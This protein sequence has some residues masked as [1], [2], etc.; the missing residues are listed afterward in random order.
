MASSDLGCAQNPDRSLWDASEIHFFNDV[1]DAVP[2]SGP[3]PCNAR[4]NTPVHLLFTK[5]LDAPLRVLTVFL[6]PPALIA[7][8]DVDFGYNAEA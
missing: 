8:L 5:V 6:A 7:E 3:S 2:I 1:D 4:A